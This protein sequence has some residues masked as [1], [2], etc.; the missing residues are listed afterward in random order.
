[1]PLCVRACVRAFVHACMHASVRACMHACVGPCVRAC[2]LSTCTCASSRGAS[3]GGCPHAISTSVMPRDH[4]SAA[5][6][7][8]SPP[9]AWAAQKNNAYVN[10]TSIGRDLGRHVH[11]SASAAR[12]GGRAGVLAQAEVAQLDA[13]IQK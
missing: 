4:K 5:E 7:S 2:I 1:M 9:N 6:S 10:V 11:V 3:D 13:A 8:R 12:A